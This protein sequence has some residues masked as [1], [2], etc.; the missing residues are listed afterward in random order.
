MFDWRA[1]RSRAKEQGTD[2]SSQVSGN[3]P[4]RSRQANEWALMLSV[5]PVIPA[6]VRSA[7]GAY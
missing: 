5:W 1:Q 3:R 6:P 2:S 7:L 4:P